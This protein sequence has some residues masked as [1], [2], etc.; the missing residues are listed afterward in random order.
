M[1]FDHELETARG[2][3]WEQCLGTLNVK[4][5]QG[6]ETDNV[7]RK[8]WKECTFNVHGN[9]EDITVSHITSVLRMPPRLGASW[10]L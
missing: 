2:L 6:V 7:P 3:N 8:Y 9:L 1:C 4:Q 5:A 10:Y